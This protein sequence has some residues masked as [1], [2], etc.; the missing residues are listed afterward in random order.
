MLLSFLTHTDGFHSGSLLR[1]LN[2]VLVGVIVIMIVSIG[3]DVSIV[4]VVGVS[5]GVVGVVVGPYVRL[6]ISFLNTPA[7]STA[8]QSSDT[9][10]TC[11]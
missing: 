9:L 6:L 2:D 10:S 7:D 1:C 11:T 3:V 4:I 5:I 8:A